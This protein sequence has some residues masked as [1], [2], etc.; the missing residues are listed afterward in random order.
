MHK[1]DHL[2]GSEW[3]EHSFR[4]QFARVTSS[5]GT[6]RIV[7]CVPRG[8]P[9]IFENL[10]SCLEQPYYL[11]YVLH[12][13]RGEGEAGRYQSPPLS[14][15]QLHEFV[16]KF[17]PFLSGDARFDIWAHSPAENATVVWDR[18]NMLYAYGPL[19]KYESVLL[20]SGFEN[21]EPQVPGP[22]AHNYR[23]ELDRYAKELL[24]TFKWSW[25]PLHKEDEQ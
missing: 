8:D 18:H 19:E 16:S 9:E 1:L 12:T 4:P 6:H 14:L 5:S 17:K 15:E 20:S 13:P 25:S 11:L 7:S 2:L 22:H 24:V 10:V 3:V 23:Q 21:E